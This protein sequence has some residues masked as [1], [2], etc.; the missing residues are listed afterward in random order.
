[1][2]RTAPRSCSALCYGH[3]SHYGHALH[4]GYAPHYGHASHY[5]HASQSGNIECGIS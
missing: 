4:Y 3:A 5:E 2:G 1:M